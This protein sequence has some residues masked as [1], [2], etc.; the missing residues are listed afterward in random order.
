[1]IINKLKSDRT[2]F[3]FGNLKKIKD[4]CQS[5]HNDLQGRKSTA[6]DP[7]Q[8][9]FNFMGI[10]GNVAKDRVGIPCHGNPG[11]IRDL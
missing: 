10:L 11:Y 9:V 8:F 3:Q 2:L 4:K 5:T 7:A 6:M 1:M